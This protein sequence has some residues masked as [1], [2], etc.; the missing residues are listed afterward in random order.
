[1]GE[2]TLVLGNK[3]YTGNTTNLSGFGVDF[4]DWVTVDCKVT[5]KQARILING[6]LAYEGNF[7]NNIGKIV[8]F[9]YRF[10]G[11]GMV[12]DYELEQL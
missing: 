4:S 9:R 6:Q 7:D 8:G 1:V 10:I 11:A 3:K 2:I 12:N 5:N